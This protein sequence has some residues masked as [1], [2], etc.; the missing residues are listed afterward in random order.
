MPLR[1]AQ[2][3]VAAMTAGV[4][5]FALVSTF[6][7]LGTESDPDF[8]RMLLLGL[9]GLGLFLSI[10]FVAARS[11]LQKKLTERMRRD[12]EFPRDGDPVPQEFVARIITSVA[13]V[14]GFGLAG[15]VVRLIT[16]NPWALAA[17]AIAVLVMGLLFPTKT[18][19]AESLNQARHG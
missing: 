10:G 17:P 16:G 2:I 1:A 5:I 12:P 7:Q 13:L 14:E 18:S 19:A 11:L 3:I 15:C 4:V 6:V 9:G 8:E